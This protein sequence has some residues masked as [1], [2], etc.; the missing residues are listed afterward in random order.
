MAKPELLLPA[1]NIECLRA[2]VNNG[3]D[4]VYLGLQSFNARR[5]ADNFTES[6]LASV[7]QYCHDNHVKVYVTL[8]ILIKNQ[9]IEA[10]MDTVNAVAE[11][12]ADALI[13]QDLCLIPLIKKHHPKLSIHLSTQATVTNSNMVPAGVDRVI[14]A[15]EL[16]LGQVRKISGKHETEVFVHGALCVCYSGQC[17]FSSVVGGRSGNRG[18]CAQPCRKK[19]N[20]SYLLSTKDLCLLE[21]LPDIVKS[22]VKAIKVEGRLRSPLY[23]A[24]VAKIYRKYIDQ[25][26][27]WKGVLKTDLE[28]LEVVFSREFTEG[29]MFEE[30]I[31]DPRMPM[32]RGLFIGKV[33]D[34]KI[35]IKHP[36]SKG[37]GIAMRLGDE[38]KG[39]ALGNIMVNG[40]PQ[41]NAKAGDVVDLGNLSE[42]T[43]VYKTSQAGLVADLGIEFMLVDKKISKKE[44]HI[45]S[46]KK[47]FPDQKIIVRAYNM[48]SA[49]EAEKAGC[50]IIY[51]DIMKKDFCEL[52]G[53]LKKA[54]I[55]ADTP[56]I[57]FDEEIAGLVKMVNEK[58]PKGIVLGNRGLLD[59]FKGYD[60]HLKQSFN[61]FNDVDIDCYND[62]IP[63]ISSELSLEDLKQIKNKQFIS[64]IHGRMR[65]MVLKE[66]LKAPELIDES[67]RHFE[68]IRQGN[69]TQIMNYKELGLF[70]KVRQL[71]EI[72]IKHFL[73]DTKKD[74]GKYV[75]V[76]K[77]ILSGAE[78]NDT[79]IRK[80][81]TT[82]HFMK[83]VA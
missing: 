17:L 20:N 78:F 32:N 8:N 56:D 81:F 61:V 76:Y 72:G 9:E 11:S 33:K 16:T 5:K 59:Q 4:A 12:K 47:E 64:L 60:I 26:D 22:G 34:S 36:I 2:A 43:L 63:T 51:Y 80:G 50:D 41:E 28:T 29:F 83:T 57:V 67:G 31:V 75:R 6:N 53:K 19:Y 82:G 21:R 14:L 27:D 39:R 66:K 73:I 15:R 55:F 62:A 7:V 71:Q 74:L 3:A 77:K 52:Q 23:V 45:R 42:G 79:K 46:K 69:S 68:V 58:K 40:K 35:K 10:A 54:E 24:T 48:K 13:I 70:N 38:S 30:S 18:L 44:F 49:L 37:D 65:I 25:L 1:G